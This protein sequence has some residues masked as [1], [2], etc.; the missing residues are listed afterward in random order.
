VT[1]GEGGSI[2]LDVEAVLLVHAE[3]FGISADAARDRVLKPAG[4]GSAVNR[5]PT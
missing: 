3:I 1:E 5:P 2:H 4:L